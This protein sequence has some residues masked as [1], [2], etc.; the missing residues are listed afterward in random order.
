MCG[1][2][3]GKIIASLCGESVILREIL[4]GPLSSRV[5]SHV[6]VPVEQKQGNRRG[7]H[8]VFVES[9]YN[10]EREKCSLFRRGVSVVSATFPMPKPHL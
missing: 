10:S 6:F 8:F 2:F 3:G 7:C 9:S 4:A 5:F 1:E